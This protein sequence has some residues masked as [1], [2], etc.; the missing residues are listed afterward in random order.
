MMKVFEFIGSILSGPIVFAFEL[1]AGIITSVA[2]VIGGIFK[3]IKG[4]FTLDFGMVMAGLGQGL[5]GI[6]G[7][8]LR[9]ILD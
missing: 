7:F 8:I 6:F 1:I 2:D 3:I 5:K 9:I 4:I